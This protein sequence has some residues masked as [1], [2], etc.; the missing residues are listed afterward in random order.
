MLIKSRLVET[1]L[2]ASLLT[3][4]S[5]LTLTNPLASIAATN[6]TAIVDDTF[7]NSEIQIQA[8]YMKFDVNTGSSHYRGNVNIIQ[9][10]IKLTGDDVTITRKSN[11]IHNIQVNGNPAEYL[12]D[13]NSD[14]KVHAISKHME[15]ATKTHRLVLTVDASLKQSDQTVESQRIVYD[16]RNK[17]ILAGKESSPDNSSD[18]VNITLTPKKNVPEEPDAP[19][20]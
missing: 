2:R 4:L 7:Q 15:Y 11:E 5:L 20:Q 16:T 18:R 19:E 3:A 8:D 10:T 6:D 12:Q 14:N 13:E 9:G 1:L 17:V